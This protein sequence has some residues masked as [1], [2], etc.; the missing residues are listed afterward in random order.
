MT[1]IPAAR[2]SI[3]SSKS[4]AAARARARSRSTCARVLR[5]STCEGGCGKP[6]EAAESSKSD[7]RRSASASARADARARR[8]ESTS[9][10][11]RGSSDGS[12]GGSSHM[13]RFAAVTD[14]EHEGRSERE[15]RRREAR[16]ACLEVSEKGSSI[17]NDLTKELAQ[18]YEQTGRTQEAA[19]L[20]AELPAAPAAA[21]AAA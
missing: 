14:A 7:E 2:P 5:P 18:L 17:F 10:T 16:S 11:A 1:G 20:R 15:W 19:T 12:I 9:A 13:R 3:S 4:V 6:L 8:S 21:P